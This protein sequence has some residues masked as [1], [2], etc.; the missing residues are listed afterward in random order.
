MATSR[1]SFRASSGIA[2]GRAV[3]TRADFSMAS[4]ITGRGLFTLARPAARIRL[5]G[6]WAAVRDSSSGASAGL[7]EFGQDPVHHACGRDDGLPQ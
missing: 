3:T 2:R 7:P 5:S 6:P 1:R 4:F